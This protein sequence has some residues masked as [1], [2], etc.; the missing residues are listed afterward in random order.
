MKYIQYSIISILLFLFSE[1]CF[2]QETIKTFEVGTPNTVF[3]VF[4][5]IDSQFY[6][7]IEGGQIVSENPSKEG[8]IEINWGQTAGKYKLKVIEKNQY[9]CVGDTIST[10]IILKNSTDDIIIPNAFTPNGDGKNDF[11]KINISNYT[12]YDLKIFDRNGRIIFQ[13]NN[14]E[15]AWNGTFAGKKCNADSYYWT[16]NYKFENGNIEKKGTV[17]LIK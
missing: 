5:D 10:F 4:G 3:K 7:E 8:K 12:S 14:A 1:K 16:L 13:S 9:G 2:S 6:W 11:F 17:T 15:N